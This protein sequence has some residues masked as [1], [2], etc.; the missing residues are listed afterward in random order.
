MKKQIKFSELHRKSM[1]SKYQ[2]AWYKHIK[3]VKVYRD[4]NGVWFTPEK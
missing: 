3:T 4:V 1:G 2:E